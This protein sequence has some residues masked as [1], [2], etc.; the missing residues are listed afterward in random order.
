LRAATALLFLVCLATLAPAQRTIVTAGSGR[1]VALVIGNNAYPWKPLVNSAND[2]RSLAALLPKVG[3]DPKDVTLVVDANLKQMQKAGRDFVEKLRPDDLAFVFYSGHGVEVRGENY[4]IPIDFPP[5]ASDLEARDEAYSAQQLLRDLESSGAKTRIMILDACR[6]NPLRATKS[7]GGGLGRMDG[8]GTLIVFATSAGKTADDN[9]RG[10]NGLFTSELLK[11]LP[12]PG[13]PL[14]QL[15]QDVARAVYRDSAE[16][17][18][19]PAIYGLLLEDFPL[20]AGNIAPVSPVSVPRPDVDAWDAIRNSAH[21]ED[22]D[23]FLK[24]FPGSDFAPTARLKATALRRESAVANPLSA[25]PAQRTRVN[26]KDGLTYVWI[27]PGKF[28]MGC[29]PGDTECFGSERPARDATVG[30][31]FWMGQTLVTQAAYQ[32]VTGKS[33]SYFK[34]AEL[35][36]ENV[37]WQEAQSYCEATGGR[38]PTETEWEYAA[39]GGTAGARYGSLDRIAWYQANSGGQTH[40]VARKDPNAYGLYD[41]LGNVYEWMSDWYEDGTYRSLRGGAWNY[42]PTLGRASYRTGDLPT[43]RSFNVG[44]RCVQD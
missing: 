2:A 8:E 12:T 6:D 13:V 42:S 37:T 1:R 26:A 5:N 15:M 24:A 14:S 11:A 38:L 36:V 40:D 20:V 18:Q 28:T 21:P 39:R 44:V 34:G 35:P 32:R 10:R 30:K 43:N 31:G 3:F 7:T 23:D 17:K 29:S 25:T 41:M 27:P 33:P 4:L 16:K 9:P 19:T 22:F